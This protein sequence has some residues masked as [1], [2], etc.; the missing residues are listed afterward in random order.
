MKLKEYCVHKN[1]DFIQKFNIPKMKALQV[2]I[3]M[4]VS[5]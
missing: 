2:W 3:D 1:I 4:R 5:N